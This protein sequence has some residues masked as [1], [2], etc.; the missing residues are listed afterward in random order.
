MDN[1]FYLPLELGKTYKTRG[2]DKI[3]IKSVDFSYSRPYFGNIV[4]NENVHVRVASFNAGGIYRET[5]EF[6]PFDIIDMA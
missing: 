6:S 5:G 2:G 1:R 4:T 3:T